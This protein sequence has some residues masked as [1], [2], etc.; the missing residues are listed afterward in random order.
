MR[1]PAL[2]AAAAG[3]AVLSLGGCADDPIYVQAP[4]PVEVDTPAGTPA[5]ATAQLTLPIRLETT[6]EADGRQQ[7]AD[8]L[9]VMVP[10]VRRDDLDIEVEWTITN[11]SDTDG[12][13]RIQMNGANEWVAYN[14]LAF[15]DPNNPDAVPPPPL[16][17][18]VPY[19]VAAGAT[20]AGVLREDELAEASLDLELMSR[21]GET[22][23]AA[24]L[25]ID[26]GRDSFDD[27]GIPCPPDAWA[28]LVRV[29]MTL[30]A[31]THMTL[32]YA[33]RVRDH[34]DPDLLHKDLLAAPPGDLTAF[35]PTDLAPA[36]PP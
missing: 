7:K 30:V 29:D 33:I 19:T 28:S 21:G 5:T 12:V 24:L 20:L 32:D 3:A 13:A 10:F 18:D 9:G 1:A 22:P 26:Q 25:T 2:L 36:T 8:Q 27:A 4:A 14:P 16:A 15:V 31:D 23:F 6:A 34:R 11:L 17:G 35:A